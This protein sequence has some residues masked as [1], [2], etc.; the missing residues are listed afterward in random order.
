M[1]VGIFGGTFNPP[2]V[3]HVRAAESFAREAV[4]DK[5]LIIP[6][7]SP[8][9]KEYSGTV[10]AEER[11]EMCRLAFSHIE[12]AEV[13]DLE[14]LRGGRSYTVDTL[15][16]LAKEGVELYFLCG[17]DMFL[18]MDSWYMPEKIFS[19]SKIAYIRRE[20]DAENMQKLKDAALRY[21]DKYGAEC[22]CIDA[23]V[24][25]ISST[26]IRESLAEGN[27]CSLIPQS[28]LGYIKERGLYK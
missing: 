13:S 17:T 8:P 9:H 3:G 11:L 22:L 18:T 14:I 5:L 10:S 7:A 21:A 15:T 19:L 26:E 16:A 6:A 20:D 27:D 25:E 24:T 1:R 23:E 2:H 28:V 12:C 4:L